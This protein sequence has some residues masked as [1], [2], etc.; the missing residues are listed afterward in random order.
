[1]LRLQ[2][3]AWL[4]TQIIGVANGKVLL[5]GLEERTF[6][7]IALSEAYHEKKKIVAVALLVFA[8]SMREEDCVEVEGGGPVCTESA[9]ILFLAG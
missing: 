2:T 1:M 4:L 5:G 7:P 3:S 6:A 8:V 9:T